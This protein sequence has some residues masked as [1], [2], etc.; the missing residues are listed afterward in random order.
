[1]DSGCDDS[2]LDVDDSDYDPDYNDLIDAH[3]LDRGV[4]LEQAQTV[5]M[6]TSM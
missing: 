6:M 2:S 4:D 3:G 1:M 5:E